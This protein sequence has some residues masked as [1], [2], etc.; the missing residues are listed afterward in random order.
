MAITLEVYLAH[1]VIRGNLRDDSRQRAIDILNAAQSQIV[2][3]SDAMAASMHAQAPP[4]K[5]ATVRIRRQ[6]ILLVVP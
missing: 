1:Q 3:L 5:L 2:T 6:Q 4:S